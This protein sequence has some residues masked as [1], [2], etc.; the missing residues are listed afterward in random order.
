V[1]IE[2]NLDVIKT[3]DWL[4]D[5]G[6]EGGS[7]GGLIIAEGTPE[8]VAANTKSY[9]GEFLKPLLDGHAVPIRASQPA[10]VP[11]ATAS[12][13]TVVSKKLSAR[14]SAVKAS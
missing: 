14:R 12:A 7:R 8:Q 2:H 9:T 13:D 6:P 10:L 5:M 11:A 4:I 1:V 3:A